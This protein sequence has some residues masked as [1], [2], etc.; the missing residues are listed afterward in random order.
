VVAV[1]ETITIT[2]TEGFN[3]QGLYRPFFSRRLVMIEIRQLKINNNYTD[4]YG[5]KYVLFKPFSYN[6]YCFMNV[7]DGSLS[8][9]REFITYIYGARMLSL[10]L[11]EEEDV[12]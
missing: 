9:G 5:H 2:I 4:R 1:T 12:I 10:T 11:E 6:D 3:K 8:F 7:D